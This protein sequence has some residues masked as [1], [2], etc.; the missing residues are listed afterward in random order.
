MTLDI[1]T[2]ISSN[3]DGQHSIRGHRIVDLIKQHSLTDTLFL[4][5]REDLP[6]QNEKMLLEAMMIA[7]V[8]HGIEAPSIF[9]PR[10]V[11]STGNAMNVALAASALTVGEKH[12]GAIEAAA[13]MIAN[14]KSAEE[15]V[16][17]R[18]EQKQIIPGLGHK[19]YKEEDPR[20]T[21]LYSKAQALGFSCLFFEK[22]YKIEEQFREKK[23]KKLPLNVDGAMAAGMLEVKLDPA[24]GKAL[25]VISRMVGAAAHVVE[26]LKETKSYRRLN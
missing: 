10:V 16:A 22:A 25:F 23:G 7:T 6:T 4:L 24:Y 11:T 19:V 12:G 26:E 1:E 18:L 8:E 2:S 9:V 15:I 5:W 21:A 3:E 17:E 13:R 20:A 14:D